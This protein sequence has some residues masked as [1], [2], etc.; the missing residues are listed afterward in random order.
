MDTEKTKQRGQGYAKPLVG[1]RIHLTDI[2]QYNLDGFRLSWGPDNVAKVSAIPPPEI[3]PG[4]VRC[5]KWAT[6]KAAEYCAGAKP[7]VFD[8]LTDNREHCFDHRPYIVGG[9]Y[10]WG[11]PVASDELSMTPNA[12]AEPRRGSDVGTSPLLGQKS[13]ET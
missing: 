2:S 11:V 4:A 3:P 5:C 10:V 9:V 1:Q 6:C 13:E 7:H 12:G 8:R